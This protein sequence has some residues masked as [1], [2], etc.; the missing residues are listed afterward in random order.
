[1]AKGRQN[2][3][4]FKPNEADKRLAEYKKRINEGLDKY[5]EDRKKFVSLMAQVMLSEVR[6]ERKMMLELSDGIKKLYT[7]FGFEL[8]ED[9]NG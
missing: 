3:S 5:G 9:D 2:D 8:T 1:M 7:E 4:V 6:N